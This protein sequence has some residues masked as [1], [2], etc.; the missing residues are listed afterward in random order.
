M[1]KNQKIFFGILIVVILLGSSL[2]VAYV[3]QGDDY[4]EFFVKE[5]DSELEKELLQKDTQKVTVDN[6]SIALKEVLYDSGVKI[7]YCIF[8]VTKKGG[9]PEASIGAD[10]SLLGKNFGENSRFSLSINA[11][12]GNTQEA[13]LKKDKLYIY[14]SFNVLD[15]LEHPFNHQVI[16]TD[17]MQKDDSKDGAYREYIF[18]LK[19]T[20]NNRRYEMNKGAELLLSPVGIAIR[21]EN[22]ERFEKQKIVLVDKQGKENVVVD[23]E[24]EIGTAGSSENAEKDGKQNLLQYMYCFKDFLDIKEIDK[25]LFNGKELNEVSNQGRE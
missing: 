24:K 14:Y 1:G 13:M 19:D 18:Q 21:V 17:G 5:R 23:T 20:K 10:R 12:S 3:A 8:E 6:Y 7:G 22:A 15:S 4:H 16:L 11:N 25:V 2:G 9:M